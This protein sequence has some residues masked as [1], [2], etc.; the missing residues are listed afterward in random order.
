MFIHE[1]LHPPVIIHFHP[2]PRQFTLD[3]A[4]YAL[5]QRVHALELDL[6]F[7]WQDGQVVC[8]HDRA[9][10]ASPT[11]EQIIDL[12]V[13]QKRDSATVNHD[14]YQFFLVLDLK[15]DADELFDGI[16]KVLQCHTA[17][18]GTAVREEDSPRGITVVISGDYRHCFYSHFPP[19][20]INRLCIVEDHNYDGEI[21]NLSKQD[22]P[23]QWIAFKSGRERGRVNGLHAGTDPEIKGRY[24]VRVWDCDPKDFD[25]C[26]ASG[27]DQINCDREQ[28]D[29]LKRIIRDQS[30][31]GRF[32][33][34]SVRRS[35]VLLTW[36]GRS[37][38]NLYAAL[39]ALEPSG[40]SFARQISLTQLLADEISVLTS[41]GALAADGRLVVLYED[42]SAQAK[43]IRLW[44]RIVLGLPKRLAR[45]LRKPQRLGYVVGEFTSFERFVTFAG[46]GR[47]LT[48]GS[49]NNL[50]GRKPAVAVGPGGR[51]LIVYE[52]V[53][54]QGIRYVSAILEPDGVLVA[55]DYPLIEGETRVGY[56]PAIAVDQVGR[57]VIVLEGPEDQGLVY[58]SGTLS[59][60]GKIQ[61][62]SFALPRRDAGRGTVPAVAMDGNGR[63]IVAYQGERDGELW[64]VSGILDASGQ[65]TGVEFPLTDGPTRRAI[66]PAVAFDNEGWA[67]ILCE[68][69]VDH[70]FWYVYGP[71]QTG[72]ITGQQR[73][74]SIGMEHR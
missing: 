30:P 32:P 70:T 71:I 1:F 54:G 67:I 58:V 25:L 57:V 55:K 15:D 60:N 12:V 65:I 62:H 27:V 16:L 19:V 63:V 49:G 4:Q 36:Q 31:R 26:L 43:L 59:P 40:L 22:A 72:R 50:R 53:A 14:G 73:P 41:T 2:T 61:A 18:F 11:L 33:G 17:H 56:A 68:E 24:N 38:N 21:V 35:Q 34:L 13:G 46:R 74:L 5:G 3:N 37:S 9:T 69:P 52:G 6:Y 23:Y 51:V 44:H 66:N 29:A 7:R 45:F 39:G 8:N 48:V 64:Y 10:A 28:V 42:L 20:Q 47:R